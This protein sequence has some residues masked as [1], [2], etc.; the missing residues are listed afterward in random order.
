M[1]V[2]IYFGTQYHFENLNNS[3]KFYVHYF[4][5]VFAVCGLGNT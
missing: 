4:N 3:S 5:V 2:L 1:F